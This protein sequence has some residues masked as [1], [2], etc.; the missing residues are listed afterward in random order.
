[1]HTQACFF[2]L[3]TPP[4][5]LCTHII[6]TKYHIIRYLFLESKRGYLDKISDPIERRKRYFEE[7]S[8]YTPETKLE[9]QVGEK[10]KKAV[11]MHYNKWIYISCVSGGG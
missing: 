2:Y 10:E 1:M 11:E 5:S 6:K 3:S 7:K 9:L 4:P 8:D